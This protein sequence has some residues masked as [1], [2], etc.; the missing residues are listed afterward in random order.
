M[1]Y[2]TH[3]TAKN[4]LLPPISKQKT[5]FVHPDGNDQS[6]NTLKSP[7]A[8]IQRA[9]DIAQA[10]DTILLLPGEYLQ[11]I[12][13][14]RD[15]RPNE[16]IRIVGMPGVVVK[17]AGK[18]SI[19]DIRHSYIELSHFII[20]G[21]FSSRALA[22]N[23]RKKL[24]YIKGQKG[25]GITGVKLFYM[26]IKNARDECV[27]VKYQAQNNEIAYSHI[28][29]CGVEDYRFS[30]GTKSHNGEAV[31]IGT[32]PEQIAAGKN[33]TLDVDHSNQNWIHHNTFK[34]YGSE[35]VD[36]KEGSSLNIIEHN[37]CMYEQDLNVGGISIR[38]N[39]NTVR[40]NHVEANLG[41]GIRLGGDDV[42]DGINNH[43]YGN[44]LKDNKNSGLKIMRGPQGK[45]CDNTI[46]ILKDQ[47]QVRV[48]A[49][50]DKNLYTGKCINKK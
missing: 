31:Y 50:M 13:S 10:G 38:G 28:S 14:V 12:A 6:V 35:C 39:N 32:A 41:A 4:Q 44:Y 19:F 37:I 26:E 48:K 25:K 8:S 30:D 29:Y 43:V 36:V 15:G 24:V 22:T 17:G 16:P 3:S 18:T 46:I 1:P 11:D 23:F 27:R 5:F 7:F 42:N 20:D 9:V 21:L 2:S 33:P 34:P 45:I 49:N 47:I 40:H